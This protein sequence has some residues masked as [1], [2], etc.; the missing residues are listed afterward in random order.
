MLKSSQVN[1]ID[2]RATAES[3]IYGFDEWNCRYNVMACCCIPTKY[4]KLISYELWE[5]SIF[6]AIGRRIIAFTERLYTVSRRGCPKIFI[7]VIVY[8]DVRPYFS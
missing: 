2:G 7:I 8:C 3:T 1:I 6:L 4:F 5:S